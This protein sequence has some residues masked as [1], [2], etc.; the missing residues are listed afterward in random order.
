M[1]RQTQRE[2]DHT[3]TAEIAPISEHKQNNLG[4]RPS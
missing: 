1:A 4:S 3:L 2:D